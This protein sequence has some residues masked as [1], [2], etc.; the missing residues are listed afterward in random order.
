MTEVEAS[1]LM[2][3]LIAAYPAAQVPPG[4]ARTY[5]RFLV[6]LELDRAVPAVRQA[7]R[8]SKFLPTIAEIVTA[9]EALA[10]R[11]PETTYRLFRP[12]QVDNPMPPGELKAAI[13]DFLRKAPQ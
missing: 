9:Y 1:K 6:E 8:T 4:T 11:K 3:M 10:P 2:A 7:I 5:E 12:A 13:D